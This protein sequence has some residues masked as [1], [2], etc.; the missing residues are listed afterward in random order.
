MAK[1]EPWTESKVV[2]GFREVELTSWNFFYEYINNKV[3][4]PQHLIWRGQRRK[5]WLLETTLDRVLKKKGKEI[6]KKKWDTLVKNHLETFKHAIRG[7]RG[8]NPPLLKKDND[9]WT[10][11]RHNG[12]HA[13]LLDWVTSPFVAA[14]FAFI[15]EGLGQTYR[16]AI[17]ALD[18]TFVEEKSK[19]IEKHYEGNERPPIIE[20]VR[21]LSDENPRLINQGGLFTRAPD[22]EDIQ[23]WTQSKFERD[24]GRVTLTKIT[25]PNRDRL[26]CL[27]S[28]N[29]MNINH[30]TLFPDLYGASKFCNLNL[31]ID[32]Y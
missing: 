2:D 23:A 3:L 25:L 7:R 10:L 4:D 32:K 8:S 1:S 13:P 20:F 11:G 6:S 19:E 27:R 26:Q 30:L 28:L 9:W 18:K 31:K 22:G 14:Y 17:Y 5:G 16:R 24:T 21:P 15:S 12:L 29:R